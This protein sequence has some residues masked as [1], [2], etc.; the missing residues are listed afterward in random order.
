MF[1]ERILHEHVSINAD[2]SEE[3]NAGVEVSMKYI[4]VAYAEHIPICPFSLGILS[5]QHGEG[6]QKSQVTDREIKEIDVTAVPVLQAE[7]VAEN[8][9]SIPK[10][11]YNKLKPVKNGKVV[12]FQSSFHCLPVFTSC[13][14]C[15]KKR[16]RKYKDESLDYD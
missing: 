10:D 9:S 12:L 2:K 5:H 7:E 4:S 11:S 3:K 14:P 1:P 6:T 15:L 16:E 13:I 8:N